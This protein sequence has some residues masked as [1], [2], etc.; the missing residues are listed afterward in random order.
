MN[1][2][3]QLFKMGNIQKSIFKSS[4]SLTF[5]PTSPKRFPENKADTFSS[6]K[7]T[8]YGLS[9]FSPRRLCIGF[10]TKGTIL[11][12]GS[13]LAFEEPSILPFEKPNSKLVRLYKSENLMRN[14]IN[15][16][17]PGSYRL[18]SDFGYHEP[19]KVHKTTPAEKDSTKETK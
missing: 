19:A 3:Q 10:N 9:S 14:S 18:P 4:G 1:L 5:N 12:L 17:R 7:I 6:W 11:W 15:F 8:F 2:H 16:W 13:S